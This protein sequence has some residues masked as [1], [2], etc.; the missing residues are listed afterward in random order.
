MIR[1]IFGWTMIENESIGVD[2]ARL[3]DWLS[4][5]RVMRGEVRVKA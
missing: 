3:R 2:L 4:L 5:P 1:M